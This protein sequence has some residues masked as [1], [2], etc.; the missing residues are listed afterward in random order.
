MGR[1]FAV[2][3]VAVVAG[4]LD[5]RNIA[6]ELVDGTPTQRVTPETL[7]VVVL[8]VVAGQRH[9]RAGVL[10]ARR[11]AYCFGPTR[12]SDL[13]CHIPTVGHPCDI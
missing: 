6:G 1:D 12:S 7:A 11:N 9:D 3:L 8:P 4:C 2:T 13:V 10:R 5:T